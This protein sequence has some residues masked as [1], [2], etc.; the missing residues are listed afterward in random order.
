MPQIHKPTGAANQHGQVTSA[1]ASKT[2]GLAPSKRSSTRYSIVGTSKADRFG[3][4]RKSRYSG[5][6]QLIDRASDAAVAPDYPH[7][8]VKDFIRISDT[9]LKVKHPELDVVRQRRG[10]A[11]SLDLSANM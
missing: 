5:Q 3:I 11:G 9:E 7:G 8:T 2:S 6:P 4:H 1:G 10:H